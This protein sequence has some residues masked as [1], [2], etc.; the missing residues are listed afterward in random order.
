MSDAAVRSCAT[1]ASWVQPQPGGATG[2]CR[3]YPPTVDPNAGI[4][5][6]SLWPQTKPAD[7]CGEWKERS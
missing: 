2:A 5:P 1:C 4:R 6:I 3:R 7:W